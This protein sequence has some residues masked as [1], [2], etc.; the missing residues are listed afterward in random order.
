MMRSVPYVGSKNTRLDYTGK[1]NAARQAS[2]HG[3]RGADQCPE[4]DALHGAD[5]EL[6]AKHR[7]CELQ[8]AG[9]EGPEALGEEIADAF[10]L[11]LVEILDSSSALVRRTLRASFPLISSATWCVDRRRPQDRAG[12]QSRRGEPARR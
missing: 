5:L 10:V 6:F 2:P 3:T 9:S 4:A 1:A 7:L 12:R 8:R 11:H